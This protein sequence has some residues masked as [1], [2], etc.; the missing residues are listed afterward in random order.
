MMAIDTEAFVAIAFYVMCIYVIVRVT[1]RL[2]GE[3]RAPASWYRRS[4]FWGCF[5]AFAQIV[6]YALWS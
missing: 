3:Q 2:P 5:V 4:S 6:V 1:P